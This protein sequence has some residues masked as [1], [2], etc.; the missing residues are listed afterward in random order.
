M[1]ISYVFMQSVKEQENFLSINCAIRYTVNVYKM[2]LWKFNTF[3]LCIYNTRHLTTIVY[4][5]KHIKHD[6]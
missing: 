2:F 6:M 4:K 3:I 1:Q 5:D